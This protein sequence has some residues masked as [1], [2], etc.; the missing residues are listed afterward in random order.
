MFLFGG[1]N[2]RKMVEEQDRDG[3]AD[4]LQNGS[5]QV[6]LEAGEALARLNDERG[7]SYLLYAILDPTDPLLQSATAEVLAGLGSQRAVPALRE[8]GLRAR[9]E[10]AQVIDEALEALGEAHIE[11]DEIE[12]DASVLDSMVTPVA[13]SGMAMLGEFAEPDIP[14]ALQAGQIEVR[15]AE[16][17]LKLAV[18]LRE[19]ELQE[20]G[21][22]EARLASWQRPEWAEPWYMRGVMLED[23]ERTREALLA[24][25]TAVQLDPDHADAR[26]ALGELLD[27]LDEPAEGQEPE[28]VDLNGLSSG[29]WQERRDTLALLQP[30]QEVSQS[31]LEELLADDERE[32]R[33]AAIEA[34]ARLGLN[35]AAP[36]LAQQPESSWL[37]RFAILDTLSSLGAVDGLVERLRLEWEAMPPRNAVLSSS[38]DPLAE[39]E[40]DQLFE[41]GVLALERTGDVEALLDQVEGFAWEELPDEAEFAD[42]SVEDAEEDAEEDEGEADE[43]LLSYVDETG[44]ILAQALERLATRLLPELNP[45]LLQRLSQTPDLTLLDPTDEEAGP[46]LVHDLS[47]LRASAA[48]ELARRQAA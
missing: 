36:A 40:N 12:P 24:Y 9:G 30:W 21:L 32:V 22:V 19:A 48:E 42:E 3:L 1:P 25:Q 45:A 39:L 44:L 43:D 8:A 7:W 35:S 23:L 37:L 38:R 2:I 13:G 26:E 27:L 47:T 6:R 4:A 18:E 10:A 34:V 41:I 5:P 16:T 15:P 31:L 29:A 28:E 14:A 11:H 17:H 46:V 20:R 33:H